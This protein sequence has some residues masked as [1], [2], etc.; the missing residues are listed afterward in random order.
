MSKTEKAIEILMASRSL[1]WCKEC[2][3]W[4]YNEDEDYSLDYCEDCLKKL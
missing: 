4:I 3:R 1:F 2:E